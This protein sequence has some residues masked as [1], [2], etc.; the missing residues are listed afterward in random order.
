ML[1]GGGAAGGVG[2][3]VGGGAGPGATAEGRAR[4]PRRRHGARAGPVH[5]EQAYLIAK[6]IDLSFLNLDVLVRPVCYHVSRPAL[7]AGGVQRDAGQVPGGADPA[8]AGGHGVPEEGG[9]AA[10]LAL[11]QR[12]IAAQYP[13]L[14]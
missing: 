14:R 6:P 5:G 1:A 2:E 8:A 13:F 7:F 3:D 12:Q 4:W 11:H 9:V 10:Q